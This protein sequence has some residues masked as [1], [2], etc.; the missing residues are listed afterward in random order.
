MATIA[1]EE[2]GVDGVDR[3]SSA[4]SYM[5]LGD[6]FRTAQLPAGG[7]ASR[8]PRVVLPGSYQV[9]DALFHFTPSSRA[10]NQEQAAHVDQVTVPASSRPLEGDIDVELLESKAEA[11]MGKSDIMA[12]SCSSMSM[13]TD[14]SFGRKVPE[15]MTNLGV[16]A[17][18]T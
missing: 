7:Y 18:S 17:C 15:R 11:M 16:R 9:H 1:E 14:D 10:P 3:A 2:D 12:R 13:S 6:T 4:M 5:S 8:S